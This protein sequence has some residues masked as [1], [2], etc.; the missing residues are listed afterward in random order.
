MMTEAGI[1]GKIGLN[2]CG[3]GVT[4]N[5]LQAQGVDY[6][7]LPTHLALRTVLESKSRQQAMDTLRAA[8]VAS[9]CHITIADSQTGAV[10]FECTA[11]DIVEL[12]MSDAGICVHTNHLTKPHKVEG[13]M[14]LPDSPFRLQRIQDL[15]KSTGPVP[16]MDSL[17]AM[18]KDENNYP[19]AICRSSGESSNVQTLFSIVMDLDHKYAHV[20]M[21]KPTEHGETLVLR[22]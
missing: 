7:R 5:A 13:R 20:K 6:E 2:S 3:V 10:G 8:G 9:T 19:S 1:I 4:L 22:P 14:F 15:I 21:G 17:Q 12:P 11:F 16:T 18:L